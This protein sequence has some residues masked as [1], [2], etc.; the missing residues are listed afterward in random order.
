MSG[1]RGCFFN[2][3]LFLVI[4]FVPVLGHILATLMV[5]PP[6][7]YIRP[8]LLSTAALLPAATV[9]SLRAL[10]IIW[11]RMPSQGIL[12]GSATKMILLAVGFCT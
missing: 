7:R 9:S 10:E 6:P 3:V 11:N 12:F 1:N 8:A 4:V 5:L 2:T